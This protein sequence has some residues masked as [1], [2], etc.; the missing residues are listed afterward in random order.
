MST[1]STLPTAPHDTDAGASVRESIA[2]QFP[3]LSVEVR[4]Y[5]G[6][7]DQDPV[8]EHYRQLVP[9][10]Q[11]DRLY[12]VATCTGRRHRLIVVADRDGIPYQRGCFL[13]D[14]DGSGRCQIPNGIA[15][16]ILTYLA[17]AHAVLKT[18]S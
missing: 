8:L 9:G 17:S 15:R 13:E 5:S 4:I 3:R 1:S 14:L 18:L 11:R 10:A 16:Q 12:T 2:R 6:P 7:S